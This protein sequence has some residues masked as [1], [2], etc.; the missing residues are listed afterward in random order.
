[1]SGI[2]VQE[3][4]ELFPQK[5]ISLIA[6]EKSLNQ[7]VTGVTLIE[8]PDVINWV[9]GGELLLT[10]GYIYK[11]N[12]AQL[13]E[14]IKQLHKKKAAALGIKLNRYIKSLPEEIS[15]TASKLDFPV[16]LILNARP[17]FLDIISKVYE[18]LQEHKSLQYIQDK[19]KEDFLKEL[20]LQDLTSKTE[21][22]IEKALVH[23]ISPDKPKAVFVIM[24]KKGGIP[25][26]ELSKY[27][28]I[29]T[30]ATG[31]DLLTLY[32]TK[33]L[34]LLVEAPNRQEAIKEVAEKH[35]TSLQKIYKAHF[36]DNKILIGISRFYDELLDLPLALIEAQKS[37]A[38]G[39]TVWPENSLFH[40]ENMG[41]YRLIVNQTTPEEL[42]DFYQ[43]MLEPLVFYDQTNDTNL[44]PTL[45]TF[46]E[47][48]GSISLTSQKLFVHYNTVK[49]RITQIEEL[50]GISLKNAETRFNLQVALKIHPL[51]K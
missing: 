25:L 4:L 22:V 49:Y 2:A 46:L 6:G 24:P 5:N 30:E 48:N 36:P 47:Q 27:K 23:N 13:I 35:A 9:T 3:V 32:K 21:E 41:F 20:L 18:K 1:M 34:A 38:I 11:D 44:V 15:S 28:K 19:L 7:L 33:T 8:T 29:C 51:L 26:E 42:Q 40:Y 43:D 37:L 50:L 12:P 14:L 16:F 39:T 10:T 31:S 45:K 17:S